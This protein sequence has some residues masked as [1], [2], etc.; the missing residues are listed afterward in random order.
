MN[1]EIAKYVSEC[2]ICQ[3]VKASHLKT[4]GILQPLPIPSWKWEDI[5]LDFIVGLPNTSLRH[6]S[7]WV[8]VDRLTKTAHFLP[9]H[10][11][12]NAKK[13]AEIYLDQ[14]VRLHGVPKTIIFDRGAQFITRF[15]EQLQHALG[16][17]LIRSSAYH[18][19]TDGQTERVNQILEDML[20]ACVLQYDKNWDK[21]LSLA[22]FSYNN[23]YQTSLKM[24]PFEALY[25][26]H[27]RTPLSWSQTGERKI[28]GPD[29][30]TK[31][32]EK[33]KTIQSNLKAAQSR[34]KSYADI[35]RRPLQFQVGDFV[36]LQVSPTRG[37]Q[38]FGVK[39]KLAPRYVEP[40]D[41]LEICG[42]V[43]Y[44]LLLPPQ[45]AAIH[46]IFHVSQLRKCVK[47]PTEVIDSQ[48][49]EIEPDLTYTEH[50]LKVLDTKERSTRRETTKMFK[51]QWSHHTEEEATWETKSYLQRNFPDFL[52]ANLQT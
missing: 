2:D 13:Y 34:Q 38:R 32:E 9:V 30:V 8:I 40:F 22:K 14:I 49:V 15:W 51:I 10:T 26:R 29:L 4:A 16:T 19:Q 37:V 48:T 52:Q 3:R 17:K 47:V 42:P 44:R 31:A 45:L 25:G 21:C 18:P 46:D 33:V 50:P 35:R 41:I 20:R 39:G 6:D 1:R 23:S 24:A 12:Y 36:Y 27:C 5:S 28:F 11:T 43:A 7:I